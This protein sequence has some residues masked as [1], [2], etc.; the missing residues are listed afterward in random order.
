[1]ELYSDAYYVRRVLEGD[2]ASFAC[3][4]D[5]YS[6]PVYALVFRML[7]NREDAEELTQDVFLKVFRSLDRFRGESSFST[8]LYRIAYRTAV[9]EMRKQR[10]EF[11]VIGEE[12]M[13]SVSEDC[14]EEAPGAD[15]GLER[16][17]FLEK[18]LTMLA[19][20]ERAIILLFYTEEKSVEE[21]AGITGL[22]VS[23]VKTRLHRIRRKLLVL[24]TQMEEKEK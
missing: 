7:R 24:I 23:N 18:A 10:H 16:I 20:E 8:W 11:P 17:G 22:S 3:L 15:G 2:A 19:P 9:S 5:R 12:L 4:L 13:A 1:M 21:I 6:R 14:P